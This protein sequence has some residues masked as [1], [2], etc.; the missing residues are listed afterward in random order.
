MRY[1]EAFAHEY[2]KEFIHIPES[3]GGIAGEIKT[4]QRLLLD[5]R[6]HPSVQLKA[7]FDKLLRRSKYPMEVAIVGQ[8]SSGKSTFLNALLSKDVLPT[9]ITPVTSKVN[10]INYADEYKLK[11]TYKNG[12]EEYH[13]LEAISRF[14]DQRDSVEDIKYLTLYAPMD[15]LRDISFVDTPGLN[16]QSFED[17]QSTKKILRDVDGIIWLTLIDNAGKES[18]AEVLEEY[19]ENFKEKSLC[20]LNQK[21]KFTAEQIEQTLEHIMTKFSDFFCEVVPISARQALASRVHQKEVLKEN[22]LFDIQNAFKQHS[23]KHSSENDLE[24]F[25]Q[26]YESF[27]MK[28]KHIEAEDNTDN[29]SLMHESNIS[30]VIEFI[31][32]TLR[33]QAKEAKAYALRNDLK[34]VCEILVG[35]FTSI[36]GV[37]ESLETILRHK[38]D[39]ITKAFDGV[40]LKYASSLYTTYDKL[41]I[42][43][44]TI[45]QGIY[46]NIR[47]KEQIGYEEGKGILGQK[48]VTSSLFEALYVDEEAVMQKLFYEEQYIDKQ[49]KSTVVYFK[50]MCGDTADDLQGVFMILKRAV[51]VWQE[52]YEQISKHREIASDLEFA[53]T[54]QF[55]AKVYENILLPYHN[56]VLENISDV[57]KQSAFFEGKVGASYK[58]LCDESICILQKKLDKQLQM[59]LKEPLRFAISMPS[60]DTVLE[61]VRNSYELE[62]MDAF[63]RSRRNYLYKSIE[64]SKEQFS[65][66]NKERIDYILTHKHAIA[67]KIEDI[68]KIALNIGFA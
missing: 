23:E 33:P 68:K 60:Y 65:C 55:V 47:T 52:P 18:E 14:T 30:Q 34:S 57:H 44:E 62:K 45:A 24:F 58:Q 3:D 48:K 31:E 40:Y 54:R 35:E 41:N 4:V 10:Y 20:V 8:F 61:I 22:A 63:L 9:G 1:L 42:I 50:R 16:S 2:K 25:K 38:E 53:S 51:Q 37:Y 28:M 66:I 46:E 27:K 32:T 36:M 6:F 19:L 26:T 15:I 49:I 64:S 5:E 67:E 59:H 43:I 13:V 7:L 29:L 39:E 17:T 12:A 56:A 21:D 11:V